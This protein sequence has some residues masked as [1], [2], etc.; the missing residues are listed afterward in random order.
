MHVTKV[1][2][3]VTAT[4]TSDPVIINNPAAGRPADGSA[5][6]IQVVNAGAE[7]G[8]RTGTFVYL[9]C[10]FLPLNIFVTPE[11]ASNIAT[12]YAFDGA[13]DTTQLWDFS[14][15]ACMAIKIKLTLSGALTNGADVYLI[16]W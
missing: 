1:M 10:T 12:D 16:I 3:A 15:E 5:F 2:D 4:T 9:I 8:G 14:P 13:A 6:A 11:N 7:A